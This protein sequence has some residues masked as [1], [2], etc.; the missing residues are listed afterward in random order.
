MSVFVAMS[1]CQATDGGSVT[2]LLPVSMLTWSL[3]SSLHVNI[4]HD[5]FQAHISM[6]TCVSI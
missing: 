2:S 5:Y 3:I 6:L 1:V 4:Y